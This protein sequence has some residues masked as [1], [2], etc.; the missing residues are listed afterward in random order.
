[1]VT[2]LAIP[3]E[4]ASSVKLYFHRHVDYDYIKVNVNQ[5][6]Y[7]PEQAMRVPGDWGSQVSRQLAHEGGKVVSPTPADFTPR[8]YSWYSFLLD[9]RATVR[10]EGFCQLKTPV[11]LPGIEPAT[12]RLVAQYL[13]QLP[14]R[15]SWLYTR[16][17]WN[18][19]KK[20]NS[21]IHL[22]F[23]ESIKLLALVRTAVF[24]FPS[25]YYLMTL[26]HTPVRPKV[27][28]ASVICNFITS[29]DANKVEPIQWK[30]AALCYKRFLPHTH[31]TRKHTDVILY[32]V[33][34]EAAP[35]SRL[36]FLITF[37]LV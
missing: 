28:V 19:C 34:Q 31:D 1:M 16:C 17:I 25:S 4:A 20:K 7:R 9:P 33:W 13:N 35:W 29:T 18:V 12:F 27:I 23:S 30:F 37:T 11:T 36:L 6:L 8:K 26:Y 10:P 32:P 5:S 3:T 15:V 2:L 22:V 24:S 21:R 14:H